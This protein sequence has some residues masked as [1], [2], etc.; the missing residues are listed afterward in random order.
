MG[1]TIAQKIIR[2][3]LVSG[4][5]IPGSD[6]GLRI[7]QTLT[8]DAT[9]TMAYL[10][11]EAMGVPRVKT[12]CSVAYIDHNTLQS[13]FENADD[14]QFIQ[15][16][17]KKHGIYFSR[18]GNGICHQLHLERF[19]VPGKTLIGSDSHTPTGGGIGMLAFGAG[20]LDVAVAMGGGEYHINMPKM[21][22]INLTG[23]LSA[24]VSAKDVILA[25]LQKMSVKGGVGKI[26][27][28]GGEGIKTLSV[29]ERATI[30]N[31]G[32]ELGATTSIFPSD[33]ITKAFLGA[34]GRGDCWMELSSDEDAIY[35]EIIDLDLSSLV[36][37]AA[38]PHSPDAVK[39]V[40]EIGP[41]KIDQCCIGSCTNSSYLDMM[42]VA[43]V[44]KGKTV[45][46]EVSLTIG[47]GSKQVYNMLALNGALADIIAAGARVLECACGPCIGMGQ[48][49]NSGGVSLRTFN[50][51]FE[52]RSGTAD[53]QVYLVSPETA[54]ASA[55]NGYFTNPQSLGEP[56]SIEL[57]EKFLINDNMIVPPAPEALMETV[58]I[59][60][61][62]NIKPFPVS[63]ALPDSI[64]KKAVLKVGDNITTDH[65][66]PAGAKILPYRSNIPYLSN[67]C[68]GV[69]DKEFPERCKR[70]GGGIVI[71]GQNYGQGS[72]REHAALVPLYLGIKAV[73]AKSYARIHCANL[74]N[75]GLIPLEFKVEDDYDRIDQ[76]DELSLPHIREE[77]QA[78]T[79]VTL[80][81]LTKGTEISL[82]AVLTDR[83]RKMVLAGGLL[84]Y[85]KDTAE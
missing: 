41:I 66:M 64:E 12:E 2:Q 42:R 35:D 34:Q 69:C 75:A 43:A 79:D 40:D 7:D 6:I 72:S 70:E 38:C 1:S 17:A 25:V 13:G 32:T 83:Q 59:K 23:K 15:S 14:H 74:A 60:R 27:E 47:C 51:N 39:T 85:T 21:T 71:G 63:E 24:W 73:I 33:E 18:P 61:G 10:E 5:M 31:M 36:P 46:P 29:P 22:K 54:A 50:R 30:T 45:H 9:G 55:I 78:G 53:G 77:L 37:M 19:G 80:C 11:F 57:P 49:P 82:T 52:G 62:P 68:F 58:E 4:E 65:I 44:L 3:H 26:I 76:M 16:I 28:Y 8:Q 20:G 81:N 84:N 67:F 56:V 48:S